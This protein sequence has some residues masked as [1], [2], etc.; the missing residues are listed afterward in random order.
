[1][2]IWR[3][4]NQSTSYTLPLIYSRKG[5]DTIE[6]AW[7]NGARLTGVLCHLCTTQWNPHSFIPRSLS[8]VIWVVAILRKHE[9][10]LIAFHIVVKAVLALV[11]DYQSNQSHYTMSNWVHYLCANFS[12]VVLYCKQHFSPCSW[13]APTSCLSAALHFTW[14]PNL[15]CKF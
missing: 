14:K 8:V 2:F 10:L 13:G 11:P 4:F 12:G 1:M 9:S 5:I 7:V 15:K 6:T 3:H